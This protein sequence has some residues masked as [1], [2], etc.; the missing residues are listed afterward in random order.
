MMGCMSDTIEDS[1]SGSV[2]HISTRLM[3]PCTHA[4]WATLRARPPDNPDS[5]TDHT[6]RL[7]VP[8]SGAAWRNFETDQRVTSHK[9]SRTLTFISK[10]AFLSQRN[11][12]CGEE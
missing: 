6:K 10:A 12:S 1:L 9:A 11:N 5:F 8:Y 4:F 7:M 2:Q 3:A